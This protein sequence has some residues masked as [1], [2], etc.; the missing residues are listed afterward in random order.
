M[1]LER[2]IESVLQTLVLFFFAFCGPTGAAARFEKCYGHWPPMDEVRD[3]VQRRSLSG[4]QGQRIQCTSFSSQ[5]K[6]FP[7]QIIE[8]L[9]VK[10]IWL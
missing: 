10:I 6:Q 7:K 9:N 4:V 1:Q 5:L 3:W 8:N 2:V